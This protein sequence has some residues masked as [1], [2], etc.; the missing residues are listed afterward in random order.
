MYNFSF[1]TFIELCLYFS[2]HQTH[3]EQFGDTTGSV[4]IEGHDPV[5]LNIRG[6]RDHSYG[7]FLF[8]RYLTRELISHELK[9]H[10]APIDGIFLFFFEKESVFPF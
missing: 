5:Q 3:Y 8:R 1:K 4:N 10:K 6:I 2:I 7:W 9:F